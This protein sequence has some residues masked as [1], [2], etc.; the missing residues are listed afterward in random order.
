MDSRTVGILGGGQ[1]GRML[2]EAANRLNVKTI[3]LDA[4][5]SP[6]MQISNSTEHIV[7]SYINPNDIRALAAKCDVLTIEIEHVDVEVLKELQKERPSLRISPDPETIRLVQDKFL[8][9]EHLREHN[10]AVIK[11]IDVSD[12]TVDGLTNIAH[13]LGFPFVLKSKRMAYDGRGNFVV[14]SQGDIATSLASLGGMS[15]YAEKWAP[16]TKELAVMVVKT[17]DGGI[18]SYPVVET[19][20]RDNICHLCYVP[21]RVP[22]SVHFKATSLAE[23]AVKSLPGAGIFGVELFHLASGEL[24]VNEIAPRP[25]NSGHYTIDACVT[26]QFEAH[27]RAILGM[28]IKPQTLSLNTTTTNCIMLNVLGDAKTNNAELQIF[29]RALDTPGASIYLYREGI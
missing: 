12:A 24:L 23:R 5:N 2:L 26:S 17:I 28:P 25:H 11:S 18:F 8:Q 21:A 6:A 15:L 27:L 7:G 13:E 4:E 9:K 29:K 14:R 3:V 1:L 20:H 10:V 19:V 16:F 22:D